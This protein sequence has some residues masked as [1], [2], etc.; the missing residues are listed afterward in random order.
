MS[1]K[2][3]VRSVL[4]A[5]GIE[6]HRFDPRDVMVR[7]ETTFPWRLAR[8]LKHYQIDTVLDVGANT[9]QYAR[10]LRQQGFAGRIVSFEPLAAAFG[11]PPTR[12]RGPGWHSGD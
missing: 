10:M 11:L 6:V 12:T 7:Q 1:F 9:G 5:S 8:L 2:E 3:R 4:R